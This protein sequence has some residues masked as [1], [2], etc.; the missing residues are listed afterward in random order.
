[1]DPGFSEGEGGALTVVVAHGC[2]SGKGAIEAFIM[3]AH[4]FI[5]ARFLLACI[6]RELVILMRLFLVSI[7][8]SLHVQ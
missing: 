6:L 5:A 8:A 3:C 7:S 1:M 2:G 4:L